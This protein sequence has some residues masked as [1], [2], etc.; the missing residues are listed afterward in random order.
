MVTIYGLLLVI[1]L[2]KCICESTNI[3]SHLYQLRNLTSSES[4]PPLVAESSFSKA[5]EHAH[6]IQ[7]P[8]EYLQ[9]FEE[10]LRS[11]SRN[12]PLDSIH[13]N[14]HLLNLDASHKPSASLP[15]VHV[16]RIIPY[17]ERHLHHMEDE[18]DFSVL[19]KHDFPSGHDLGWNIFPTG[20]GNTGGF[21]LGHGNIGGFGS[22]HGSSG[23][24]KKGKEAKTL[25]ILMAPLILL[26]V[27]GPILAT[28]AMIPWVANGGL[29]SVSTIAGGK[30]RKRQTAQNFDPRQTPEMERRLHLFMEVQDFI[31]RTDSQGLIQEMGEAFLQCQKYTERRNKC[32]ERVAC[33][34]TDTTSAIDHDERRIGRMVL[35]NVLSNP[36]FPSSLIG[37]LKKGF[38][39]GKNHPGNCINFWCDVVDNP[40]NK[41]N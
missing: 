15:N 25:F 37:K 19:K 2:T 39:V 13:R 23:A 11:S 18:S 12:Q 32:L 4:R 21:G 24:L 10:L 20:H 33:A 40:K 38:L 31:A 8:E 28:Q 3:E 14:P 27:F 5:N 35:R 7:P 6:Y 22:N 41:P 1:Y 34:F 30:R 17:Q 26:A 16:Y 9:N 29:T 36:L